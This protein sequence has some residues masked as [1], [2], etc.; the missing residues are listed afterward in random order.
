MTNCR[1]GCSE[2]CFVLDEKVVDRVVEEL[3]GGPF[4]IAVKDHT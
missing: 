4:M 3:N 2:G 1:G